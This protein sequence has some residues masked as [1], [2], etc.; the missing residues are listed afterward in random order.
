[1]IPLTNPYAWLAGVCGAALL[2]LTG[3]G[4]GHHQKTLEDRSAALGAAQKAVQTGARQ[5][6]ATSTV[7]QHTATATAAIEVRTQT[8]IQ[9]VPIYVTRKADDQCIVSAGAVSLLDAAASGSIP[10]PAIGVPDADSGVALS[11]VVSDTIVNAGNYRQLAER[12]KAWDD[13]YDAQAKI[14]GV[15]AK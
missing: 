5:S 13:W 9:K 11:S 10:V 15:A 3:F 7:D 14:N 1:M 12:L 8:L 4:M 2:W 6:A